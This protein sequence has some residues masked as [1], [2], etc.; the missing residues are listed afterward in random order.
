MSET[1][2]KNTLIY[3]IFNKEYQNQEAK[4]C[5]DQYTN[6]ILENWKKNPNKIINNLRKKDLEST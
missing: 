1:A 3:K 2:A 5:G 6:Q 4:K